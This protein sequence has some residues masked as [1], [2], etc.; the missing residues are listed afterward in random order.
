[1]VI[2]ILSYFLL[3]ICCSQGPKTREASSTLTTGLAA[4]PEEVQ[5]TERPL[6]TVDEEPEEEIGE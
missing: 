6:E 1:M 4:N 5:E 3:G 2:F